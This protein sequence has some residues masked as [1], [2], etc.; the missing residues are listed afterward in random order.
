MHF[1]FQYLT[2]LKKMIEFLYKLKYL[3]I[4][5]RKNNNKRK[6]RKKNIKNNK[7]NKKK[8]KFH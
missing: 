2:I 5:N 3:Q 8:F 4:N 7:N 6:K 1:N